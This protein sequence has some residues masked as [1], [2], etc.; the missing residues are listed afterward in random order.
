MSQDI[1]NTPINPATTSGTQ[2]AEMLSDFKEAIMSGLSGTSRP[3][4]LEAGGGWIDTTNAGTPNFYWLYKVYTGS[5]DV[6]VFRINLATGVASF[7]LAADIFDISH[8][9]DDAV[10]AILR[11]TKERV[12]TTGEVE[13]SDVVAEIRVV[14]HADD[15]SNPTCATIKVIAL[16]DMTDTESGTAMTFEATPTG[17]IAAA[18]AM[19]I[20]NGKLGI[21][22]TAPAAGLHVHGTGILSS[23]TSADAVG[24]AVT[25]QKKRAD[26]TGGLSS[27]DVIGQVDF[28]AR[29]SSDA[30]TVTGEIEVSAN[31]THTSSNKGTT[32]KIK[33]ANQNSNTMSSKLEIGDVVETV[34]QHKLNSQLLV[35]QNIATSATIAQLDATKIGVEFT[36][37]TATSLQ[38]INSGQASKTIMLHNR[39]SAIVTL[40]HADSGAT[41]NDRFALQGAIDFAMVVNSSVEV[42][43]CIADS[44]WKM[45]SIGV[46]P[47]ASGL[48]LIGVDVLSATSGTYT[49]DAAAKAMWIEM[50]SAGNGGGGSRNGV[51]GDSYGGAG[52]AAGQVVIVGWVDANDMA[53]S[54]AYAVGA[55]GAGGTT[56]NP[57]NDGAVGDP[58]TLTLNTNLTFKAN[59]HDVDSRG[60]GGGGSGPGSGNAEVFMSSLALAR[61]FQFPNSGTV[62]SNVTQDAEQNVNGPGGGASGAARIGGGSST[63]DARAGARQRRYGYGDVTTRG[64]GGTVGTNGG[65]N[66]GAGGAGA[67]GAYPYWGAGGGGG[68]YGSTNGGAGGAGG[69]AGGGGGGAGV[70][71]SAGA[72]GGAGGRGEIRIYKY[73]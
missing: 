47:A 31:Q 1:Y 33:T 55:G 30:D 60:G 63:Q 26:S 65:A 53:S 73:S 24:P 67:N 3:T 62:N 59:P 36:G 7:A 5:L 70:G 6:T 57:G 18:E 28:K 68:G 19:R 29:D 14:G 2:L 27:A 13:A 17:Q 35:T 50:V 15:D 58:T 44:R 64:G 66:G 46:V 54:C 25:L 11:L 42:F 4:E 23:K 32:L 39:S 51:S 48:T 38:G 52:G 45:R 9:A 49:K 40:K 10:G 61:K 41:A 71:G 72:T 69:T 56:G 21:G 20:M 22:T 37:S 34:A 43:Y 8:I 12:A 16:E